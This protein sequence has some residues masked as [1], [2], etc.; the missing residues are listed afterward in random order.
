[1]ITLDIHRW[2]F[3]ILGILTTGRREFRRWM[4]IYE[5]K[6]RIKSRCKNCKVKIWIITASYEKVCVRSIIWKDIS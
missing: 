6:T 4:N 1:M 5:Q 2:N 3:I